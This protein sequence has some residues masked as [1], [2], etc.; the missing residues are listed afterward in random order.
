VRTPQNA[1][2][3]TKCCYRFSSRL[4]TAL[5]VFDGITLGT[6]S[7]PPDLSKAAPASASS[8]S[9]TLRLVDAE[10]QRAAIAMLPKRPGNDSSSLNSSQSATGAGCATLM[11]PWLDWRATAA[12]GEANEAVMDDVSFGNPPAST[13]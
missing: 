5:N 2:L 1:Q 10:L 13:A 7:T 3:F 4:M 9:T 11:A 8:P 6:G 12:L